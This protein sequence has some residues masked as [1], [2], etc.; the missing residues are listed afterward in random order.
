MYLNGTADLK[1]TLRPTNLDILT[2]ADASYNV[3]PGA[4]G[5]SG[6]CITV[7]NGGALIMAKSSKQK[8]TSKSSCEAELIAADLATAHT[9]QT[10]KTFAE[11]GYDT[12]PV[13][14]QDNEG[15]INIAH[16][17]G[18]KYRST[19]HI[20]TRFFSIK[21]LIDTNQIDLT[22]IRTEAMRAD[23]LTKPLTGQKFISFRNQLM[24]I[25]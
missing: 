23:V 3:H 10:A 13:I 15:T 17:G 25:Q 9:I 6:Y 4:K 5:H 11:F 19:K 18:G 8:C 21:A 16:N 20:D 12:I 7:G 2:F 1:L 14:G 22:H 24:N